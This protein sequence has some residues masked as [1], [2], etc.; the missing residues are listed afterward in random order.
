MKEKRQ[1]SEEMRENAWV[2]PKDTDQGVCPDFLEDYGQVKDKICF[3]LISGERNAE[4]LKNQP[5]MRFLDMAITFF[6]PREDAESGWE[7][8]S[9]TNELARHWGVSTDQ[10]ME[11]AK[12]NTP[13]LFPPSCVWLEHVMWELSGGPLCLDEVPE[14]PFDDGP[15][16]SYVLTNAKRT[17][18]AGVLLYD[19]YLQRVAEAGGDG[20][21]V[22][23]SSVDEVI[24]LPK[25]MEFDPGK[26]R[27]IARKVNATQAD[28]R[29]ILSDEVYEYDAVTQ[30]LSIVGTQEP[31]MEDLQETGAVGP[32]LV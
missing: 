17:F 15:F 22:A 13:R 1:L 7:C 3:R 20:F 8:L 2:E 5:H 9:V 11:T 24:I 14:E 28:P 18:G 6:V 32:T 29:E 16:A 21:Y 4:M 25:R 26:L 31:E 19:G 27:S 23:G 12:E 10:L 30:S